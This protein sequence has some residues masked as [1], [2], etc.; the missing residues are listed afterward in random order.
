MISSELPEILAM[1]D[2]VAV[3]SEGTI[4]GIVERADASPEALLSLAL[5]RGSRELADAV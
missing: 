4:A 1:S 3:M 5:G 2:R